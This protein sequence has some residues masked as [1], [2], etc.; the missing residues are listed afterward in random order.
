MK[1]L[2]QVIAIVLALAMITLLAACGAKDTTSETAK[3]NE[4]VSAGMLS[5]VGSTEEEMNKTATETKWTLFD[6][7]DALLL[8]LKSGKIERAN[9]IPEC[10]GQYV[11]ANDKKIVFEEPSAKREAVLKYHMGVMEKNEETYNLLNDAIKAMKEDGT[12][13]K[14]TKEYIDGYILNG[15]TPDVIEIPK[16]E[17]AKTIKVAVTGDLPPLDFV[18]ADGKAA[19]FNVAILAEIS[20]RANVN[21]ELLT[22][23]SSAR[24]VA[25]TSGKADALF[26]IATLE[27]A[28]KSLNNE[29]CNADVPESVKLTDEYYVGKS[30]QLVLGK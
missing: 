21:I 16:I 29:K 2:K 30:G 26:W 15:K 24:A 9:L 1:H 12:L 22:I 3:G 27:F 25:L 8:A 23:N 7:L 6:T 13:D 17:G 10:V 19:G 4:K 28:D 5:M 20:K 18:T 11:N 14:L